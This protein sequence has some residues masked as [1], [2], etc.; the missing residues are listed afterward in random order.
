MTPL[1]AEPY[2]V[3]QVL[4]GRTVAG[5]KDV[6]G[7]KSSE[8]LYISSD[9]FGTLSAAHE[10]VSIQEQW[11]ISIK[12][13][14]VSFQSVLHGKFLKADIEGGGALRCDSDTVGFCETF[15]VKCQKSIVVFYNI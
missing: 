7:L 8:G 15:V 5:S 6:F 10:A 11:R 2:E 3:E 9:K 14:G 1:D 12:E 4:I 13:D